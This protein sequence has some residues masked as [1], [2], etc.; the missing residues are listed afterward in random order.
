VGDVIDAIREGRSPS[1]DGREGRR[2]LAAILG[3]YQAAGLPVPA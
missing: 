3:I 2:A 1:I